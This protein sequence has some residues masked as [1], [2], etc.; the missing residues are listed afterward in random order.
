MASVSNARSVVLGDYDADGDL[1]VYI[2]EE[3]ARNRLYNNGG[4]QHSWLDVKL[5]GIVSNIDGIGAQVT[6]HSGDDTQLWAMS[7]A[8]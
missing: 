6:T 5:R 3:G 2:I 8:G 4:S 1:D 7:A